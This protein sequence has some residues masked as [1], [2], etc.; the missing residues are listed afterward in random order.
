MEKIRLTKH[1]LEQ[2][3][4]RGTNEDEVRESIL[5]GSRQEGKKG[6]FLYRLNFQY[7]SEWQGT[8]YRI[9]QVAPVVAEEK[10]EIVVITVYTFFF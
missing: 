3:Q 8:Y 6:K 1:A 7:D 4:E 9:K 5:Q 10:S 2:C